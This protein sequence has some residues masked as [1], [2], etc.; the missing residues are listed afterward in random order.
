MN[1]EEN[2]EDEDENEENFINLLEKVD[3]NTDDKFNKIEFARELISDDNLP[4]PLSD[5]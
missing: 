4:A 3:E 5:L 2:E 1:N